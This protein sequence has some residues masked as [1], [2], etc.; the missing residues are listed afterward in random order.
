MSDLNIKPKKSLGQNFLHDEKILDK[1]VEAAN[2]SGQ[3]VVLEIGPGEGA[4]TEKL[5][6]RCQ[7]L[8]A[9][10]LDD[11]L[12]ENLRQKF[13]NQKN[14]QIIHGDVLDLDLNRI[15]KE[16]EV[17]RGAYKVV[18]NLPYYITSPIIRR[19]LE[20]ELAP[21]EMI[22]MVQKEVGQ[23]IVAEPGQMS[24]L[25]VSVQ[26]YARAQYLFDVSRVAFNPVPRVDSAVLSIKT[27]KQ[28]NIKTNKEIKGFFRI[29]KMGFA[30][31]R[32]TLANNLA[33]G[34]Q[35][36]KKEIEQILKNQGFA[37]TVRAQELS[38]EDWEGLVEVL[39]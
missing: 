11:R 5:A 37:K 29:V 4:L 16:N 14:V 2:L 7:K 27:L 36:D 25:A 20:N 34:L 32:K 31:K 19:F 22:L 13:Q 12:I 21:S 26:F 9:I 1:I 6:P 10:E 38:V 24:L 35:K 39:A 18:A 3:E 23:R 30:A 28:E 17:S 8:I 33:G 15:L